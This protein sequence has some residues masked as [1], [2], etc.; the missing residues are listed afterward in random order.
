M[1]KI[2]S[3]GLTLI[4]FSQMF[5]QELIDSGVINRLKQAGLQSQVMEHA[6]WLTDVNGPRLTASKGFFDAM[7]WAEH[8]LKGFGLSNIQMHPFE[9]GRGWTPQHFTVQLLVPQ[10]AAL[11]GYALPWSTSTKGRIA[12]APVFARIPNYSNWSDST[13]DQYIRAFR[14]KLKNRIVLIEGPGNFQMDTFYPIKRYSEKELEDLVRQWPKREQNS[15]PNKVIVKQT[16]P[17]EYYAERLI[18]FYRAEQVGALVL[19]DFGKGGGVM[20]LTHIFGSNWLHRSEYKPAPP[21]FGLSLEHYNR[22]VRLIEKKIPVQMDVD[23]RNEIKEQVNTYS[24]TA[25]IEGSDKKDEVVMIGAHLDSW[26]PSTGATDNAAGVAVMME[27]MRI[28]KMVK[29]QPRRT[30]RLALW[31]GHEGEG[32]GANTYVREQFGS[33]EQPANSHKN[34]S[35]YFNL[36]NGTGKIRGIY[37]NENPELIPIFHEWFAPFELMGAGAVS[38]NTMTG[39]DHVAFE[40][41]GIPGFQFIQD[42]IN[43]GAVTHHTNMDNYDQLLEDDLKQASIIIAS[44]AYLAA[45]RDSLLPR[46]K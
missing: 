13:I 35:C 46:K 17:F 30:I 33:K 10:H 27:A 14:G 38:I 2:M 8:Q 4:I 36:D 29:V 40:R 44:F 15:Q 7:L 21:A 11:I 12:G 43:Y 28:L 32:T 6:F 9:W 3:V 39:T 37:V 20:T 16:K 19:K 23:I 31:G 41:A 5:S 45:M 42:P 34:I 24:L 18:G 26:A 1:K 25:E 22:I